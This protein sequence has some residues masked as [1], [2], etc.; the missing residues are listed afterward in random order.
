MLTVRNLTRMFGTHAAVHDLSFSIA[1]TEAFCLL[2]TNGAGKSTTLKML[3]GQLPPTSGSIGFMD[4]EQKLQAIQ[5]RD[6]FYIPEN[7]SL[8]GDM[9]AIENLEYLAALSKVKTRHE[10]ITAALLRMGLEEKHHDKSIADFS[11]GMRQKVLLAFA[12]IKQARLLL[13][14]EPTS[15]LDLVATH[16]FI[17]VVYELKKSGCAVF[18]VTHDIHC[19][20]AL[21]DQIGVMHKGR[22]VK[23]FLKENSDVADIENFYLQQNQKEWS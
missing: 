7:V 17:N 22:I 2:G 16:D 8:Y 9:S 3:L 14:D 20:F 6:I 10:K 23:T 5:S 11:K 12:L 15:G 4:S 1:D 19:A 18:M 13:L 21:A